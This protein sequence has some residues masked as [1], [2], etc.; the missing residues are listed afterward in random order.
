[1][2]C[3]SRL[4][5]FPSWLPQLALPITLSLHN[6]NIVSIAGKAVFALSTGEIV[7]KR[8]II[9][10]VLRVASPSVTVIVMPLAL[11]HVIIIS[12]S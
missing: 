8:I 12:S 11:I 7:G 2:S 1:M 9:I 5:I 10:I 4:E 6:Y 3:G